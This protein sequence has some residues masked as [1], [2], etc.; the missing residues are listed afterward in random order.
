MV[1][2][3]AQQEAIVHRDLSA[4]RRLIEQAL[5][6][7]PLQKMA[8]LNR[9]YVTVGGPNLVLAFSLAGAPDRARAMLDEYQREVP[10]ENQDG[11]A[12]RRALG[13]VLIAEGRYG[14]ALEE[15]RKPNSDNCVHC[16]LVAFARAYDGAGPTD[17]AAVAWARLAEDPWRNK[18]DWDQ[19]WLGPALERA[20]QLYDGLGDPSN[21]AKYYARFVEVWAEADQE[22]QP[23]VRAAQAR[24]EEL[25]A[26]ER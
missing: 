20:A 22:L 6:R 2:G 16:D 19:F 1:L 17:T 21:A 9:P 4:A 18:V 26:E 8:P 25:V 7:Y 24:L 14:E 3:E 5:D 11:V 12:A 13:H 10:E 23:R 15:F